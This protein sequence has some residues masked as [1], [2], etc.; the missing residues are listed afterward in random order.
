MLW[1]RT[2]K[3]SEK[4]VGSG[5]DCAKT[6][7]FHLLPAVGIDRQDTGGAGI[8]QLKGHS[9]PSE[10]STLVKCSVIVTEGHVC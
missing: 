6:R 8:T 10:R 2:V 9:N 1:Q 7:P 4:L 3:V 5:R